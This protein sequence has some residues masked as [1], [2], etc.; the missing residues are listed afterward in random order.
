MSNMSQ[1][2]F[3]LELQES[4]KKSDFFVN[5]T[6]KQAVNLVE[7]WPNW[8]NKAAIIYG[9]RKSGKSHLGN[10]WLQKSNAKFI[11]IKT[12]DITRDNFTNHCYLI[13][14][15][16]YIKPEQENII[17][18]MY[19]DA[20]FNN[21]YVLFLC[22]IENRIKFKFKDL[23]SRFNS[24]LSTSIRDP[25][26][27]V[28]EVIV[29]KYFSDNQ[30]TIARDVIKYLVGRIIRNY[31]GISITLNN[32]NDLSFKNKQKITIP[33]LRDNFFK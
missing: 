15:F 26:D 10:I 31:S 28:I 5:S 11:D 21:N 30:V 32:I 29:V 25:D 33:F 4:F 13:D 9:D 24:F 2:V 18:D 20:L 22:N 12:M 1:F 16:S 23:E 6:N 7:L 14:N 8:H 3:N 17:L 19:N 27:Q